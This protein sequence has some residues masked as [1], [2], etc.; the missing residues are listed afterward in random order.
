MRNIL[1]VLIVGG[2]IG[3]FALVFIVAYFMAKRKNARGPSPTDLRT[4][5]AAATPAAE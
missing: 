5:P 1:P 2:I 3:A 4:T